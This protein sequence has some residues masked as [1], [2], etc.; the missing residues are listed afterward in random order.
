M[1][2]VDDVTAAFHELV[3]LRAATAQRGCSGR[4]EAILRIQWHVREIQILC[5]GFDLDPTEWLVDE[6]ASDSQESMKN[7]PADQSIEL[8]PLPLLDPIGLTP[9]QIIAR[10]VNKAQ[11][12]AVLADRNRLSMEI[13]RERL[14]GNLTIYRQ[15]WNSALHKVLKMLGKKSPRA[16]E[17]E[18]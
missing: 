2:L 6:A 18:K 11:L 10:W 1:S 13:E 5:N 16:P 8:P 14:D 17:S 3:A 7:P 9:H 15:G 12:A 4:D